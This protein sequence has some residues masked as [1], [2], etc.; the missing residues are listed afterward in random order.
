MQVTARESL[1]R[2]FAEDSKKNLNRFN[3]LISIKLVNQNGRASAILI[4]CR[5]LDPA[6]ME[7]LAGHDPVR[8]RTIDSR[9]LDDVLA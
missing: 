7:Q 8:R 3:L 9:G 4:E 6:R 1:G 2:S 5:S